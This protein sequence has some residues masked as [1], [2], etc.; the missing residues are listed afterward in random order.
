MKRHI[1]F[2]LMMLS[3]IAALT[4]TSA[5]GTAS[6]HTF[7]LISV[8]VPFD[9]TDGTTVFPAGKYIIRLI[10][11]GST[12]GISTRSGDGKVHGVRWCFTAGGTA[13][14]SE[15]AL[16]F[17][18]YGDRYFL[19]Q[20]WTVGKFGRPSGLELPKSSSE[21]RLRHEIKAKNGHAPS[22]SGAAIVTILV[23]PQQ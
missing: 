3:L 8:D 22:S 17:N 19:S 12:V 2:V 18:R 5:V 9:F 20:I 7:N 16:V 10:G 14:R 1:M 15:S 21:R 11:T 13:P 4:V 6:A 23:A